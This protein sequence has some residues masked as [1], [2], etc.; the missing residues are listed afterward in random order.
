MEEEEKNEAH[1]KTD[2]TQGVA[3]RVDE[4]LVAPISKTADSIAPDYA[5]TREVV[6]NGDRKKTSGEVLFDWS[7]YGGFGFVGNEMVSGIIQN[8]TIPEQGKNYAD[9]PWGKYY[10]SALDFIEKATSLSAHAG[11]TTRRAVDIFVMTIGGNLLVIPIKICEDMKGSLV[12]F[13]DGIFHGDKAKTDPEMQRAH[14]E[15]DAA[16][17]QSWGSLAQGRLVT[18]GAAVGVDMLIGSNKAVST[19]LLEK[20]PVDKWSSLHRLNTQIV[21]KLASWFDPK[22]KENIISAA[23]EHPYDIQ[24]IEGKFAKTGRTYGFLLALSAALAAGFYVSSHM[25]ANNR[26]KK[27]L[28]EDEHKVTGTRHGVALDQENLDAVQ[29]ETADDK[30]KSKVSDVQGVARVDQLERGVSGIHG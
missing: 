25:F 22:N 4:G 26:E 29:S 23:K 8:R 7:I 24:D 28:H 11:S 5:L 12:R 9:I 27:K 20:T 13:A 17:K 19:K 2:S 21:R 16:P 3:M 18:I 6:L 14:A 10:K 30:P 1:K 15:M